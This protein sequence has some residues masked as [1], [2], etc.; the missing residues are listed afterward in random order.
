MMP[1]EDISLQLIDLPP[2]SAEYVEHW[3]YDMVRAADLLWLV[4]ESGESIDGLDSILELLKDKRIHIYPA[5][6]TPP[7]S[8]SLGPVYKPTLLVVSGMDRPGSEE[9]VEILKELMKQPWPVAPVSAVS[10]QGTD[11]LKRRTFEL[12]GLVRVYTKQPGKLPDRDEPFTL[13][14]GSTL[15]ELARV[16]H[17]DISEQ[18]KFARVWGSEVF[19]GQT[20]QRDYVLTEGDVIEIHL[21]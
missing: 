1:F 7:E 13:L 5:G 4:A 11:A 21:N 12:L 20:V 15:A 8:E 3:V 9:N 14:K 16:I 2:I 10:G 19:D 6:K 18:F 17:R